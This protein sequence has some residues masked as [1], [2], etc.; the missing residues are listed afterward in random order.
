M[1]IILFTALIVSIYTRQII[2]F[3]SIT[4]FYFLMDERSS[5]CA[6]ICIPFPISGPLLVYV[7]PY[8]VGNAYYV[9]YMQT[10]IYP[11]QISTT[12]THTPYSHPYTLCKSTLHS[13]LHHTLTP[14]PYTHPYTIHS[15]LHPTQASTTVSS[16]A[17][18]GSFI[19]YSSAGPVSAIVNAS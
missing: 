17:V 19:S 2:E 8:T 14:T 1:P 15:P 12:L 9:L 11:T 10:F 13:P 5:C 4:R 18:P 16:K 3:I 7:C 6:F